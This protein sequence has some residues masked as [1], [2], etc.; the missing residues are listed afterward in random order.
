LKRL[1]IEGDF[2][3][4]KGKKEPSINGSIKAARVRLIDEDGKQAGIVSIS[5]ALLRAENTGLDLV[6]I[7]ENSS[8]PVCKILDF[9]KYR[10]E[11]QKQKK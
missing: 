10:Y 4:A 8:P 3:I 9:G 11:L 2:N 6:E 5:D 7:S 1:I